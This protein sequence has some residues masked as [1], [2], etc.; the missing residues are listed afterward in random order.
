MGDLWWKQAG[1]KNPWDIWA[2]YGQ[3]KAVASYIILL[4]VKAVWISALTFAFFASFNVHC[5]LPFVD[6]V[7][8]GLVVQVIV[9][10]N[11]IND[12]SERDFTCNEIILNDICQF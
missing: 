7:M 12:L 11:F 8:K 5:S 1:F 6:N 3:L 9:A 4:S 10:A 2:F